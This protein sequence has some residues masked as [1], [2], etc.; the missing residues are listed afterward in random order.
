ME[1]RLRLTAHDCQASRGV[2]TGGHFY[3]NWNTWGTKEPRPHTTDH[4][5]NSVA[6]IISEWAESLGGLMWGNWELQA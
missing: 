3:L 6:P 1:S 4:N 2:G 5:V